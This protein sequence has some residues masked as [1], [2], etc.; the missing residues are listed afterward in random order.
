MQAEQRTHPRFTPTSV[1]TA[2]PNPRLD[3]CAVGSPPRAWGRRLIMRCRLPS[4]VHPH[5]RGDGALTTGLRNG[6]RGSPPR[7]WGRLPPVAPIHAADGSP[8]RAWGRLCSSA[9]ACRRPAVHPHERGDGDMTAP[10]TPAASVHPHERGD[11]AG[12][13]QSV[14]ACRSVH[15]HERG[16]GVS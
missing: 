8:P 2:R 5:E 3:T 11:G 14:V 1:G 16:D 4:S 12:D 9:G 13:R 6:E 15:P 10:T 7:A